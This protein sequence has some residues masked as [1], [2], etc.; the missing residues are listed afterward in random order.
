MT[1]RSQYGQGTARTIG[2]GGIGTAP[3]QAAHWS[4]PLLTSLVL[5][6]AAEVDLEAAVR[7]QVGLVLGQHR[8]ARRAGGRADHRLG[9]ALLLGEDQLVVAG[10]E[11]DLGDVA[12]GGEEDRDAV[13]ALA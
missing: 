13:L 12:V 7:L 11:V 10:G 8:L 3:P 1:S 5:L 6:D 4:A 9:Q 2:S